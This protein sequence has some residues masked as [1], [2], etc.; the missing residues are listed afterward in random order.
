MVEPGRKTGMR[1]CKVSSLIP[2]QCFNCIL[3]FRGHYVEVKEFKGNA[4][5]E[6]EA[7]GLNVSPLGADNLI[8]L[9]RTQRALSA[10]RKHTR[11]CI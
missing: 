10:S 2:A 9:I 8:L 6:E 1:F 5:G 7:G 11:T 4:E 3:A